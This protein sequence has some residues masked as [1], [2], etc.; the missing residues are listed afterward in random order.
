MNLEAFSGKTAKAVKQD[1][2][3][4]AFMMTTMAVLAFPIEEKIR[5][6]HEQQQSRKHPHKVNRT[7][8]LA[9]VKEIYFHAI[10]KKVIK[11][12]IRAFDAILHRTTEII[13]PNRKVPR[14]H[15]KK[16]AP[17]MNYKQL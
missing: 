15:I 7:N 16:K 5:N 2:Y 4:K 3:A 13:R 10:I 9:M 11:P 12:A 14:N 6:E 1:I 17:S 8:G